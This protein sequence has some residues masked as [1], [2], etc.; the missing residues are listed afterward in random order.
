MTRLARAN[1]FLDIPFENRR[2]SFANVRYNHHPRY[3]FRVSISFFGVWLR[4]D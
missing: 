4:R 2:S 3:P 1:H